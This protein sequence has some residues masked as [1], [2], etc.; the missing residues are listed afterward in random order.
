[1]KV[2]FFST[3]YA[4]VELK[5]IWVDTFQRVVDDGVFIGGKYVESFERDWAKYVGSKYAVGVS[6]GLDGLILALRAVGITSGKRVAV[7]AHTFI[8]TWNAIL[9]VGAIPVGI[10]VDEN[11]LINL[12][13]LEKIAS[14]VEAVLPVHMHGA[15][16]NMSELSRICREKEKKKIYIIED[17]SQ[18]HG[19]LLSEVNQSG[20]F[21]DAVVYSL[22]PTKNLG[23]LGDAGI[24]TTNDSITNERIQTL[25]NYGSEK[26]NKYRHMQLGFNNR[27][28]PI[29]AAILS[30]NLVFLDQWN[31]E[32]R[33]LADLYLQEL[34]EEYVFLQ[35]NRKDSVRHHLCV[36]HERRDELRKYLE[37]KGILTEIH[38]PN[39]AGIEVENFSQ[40]QN[41]YIRSEEIARKTLS[42]PLSQWHTK[43]QVSYVISKMKDWVAI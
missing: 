41:R 34:N 7:P 3:N 25:R 13:E 4:P 21:S 15:T 33:F 42:L 38:Y 36:L 1:M 2:D 27:L 9:T 16:V 37:S 31:K 11:G 14:E 18:A 6:N 32:R 19:A 12:E 22:Y 30:E 5:K 43:E 39:V 23:A 26:N 28:D 24:V 29:Q 35:G 8:A 40:I 20:L 10:D 17:A